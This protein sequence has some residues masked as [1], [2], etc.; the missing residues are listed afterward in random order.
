MLIPV[1]LGPEDTTVEGL[2]TIPELTFAA[3]EHAISSY[4]VG[5]M[6]DRDAGFQE[7][8]MDIGIHDFCTDPT[9]W[10][11]DVER[12]VANL[13]LEQTRY[14]LFL[15]LPPDFHQKD[16]DSYFNVRVGRDDLIEGYYNNPN[17]EGA[18]YGATRKFVMETYEVQDGWT[19]Q[20]PQGSP[21]D[22]PQSPQSWADD[23]V[24][25]GLQGAGPPIMPW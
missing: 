25:Q 19:P 13:P 14:R 2:K 21:Q 6:L 22:G 9:A 23:P 8:E 12:Q 20:S 15:V 10:N 16:G 17:K 1:K 3:I 7:D 4:V 24:V 5:R 11:K 18:Y